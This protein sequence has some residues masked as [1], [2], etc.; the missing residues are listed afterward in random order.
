MLPFSA[1]RHTP[2]PPPPPP[3]RPSDQP[4]NRRGLRR[5]EGGVDAAAEKACPRR[6]LRGGMPGGLTVASPAVWRPR[7]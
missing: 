3:P 4:P 1:R 2:P 7:D 5:L 6:H